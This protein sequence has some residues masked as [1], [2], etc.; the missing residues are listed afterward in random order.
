MVLP[1]IVHMHYLNTVFCDSITI[2]T[3]GI[4]KQVHSLTHLA[5]VVGC[6]VVE[7]G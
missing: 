6:E 7:E 1:V 5:M 4:N 3:D 2:D